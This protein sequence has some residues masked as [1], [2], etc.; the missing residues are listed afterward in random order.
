MDYVLLLL[1]FTGYGAAMATARRGA[2][3]Q[4]LLAWFLPL[5][6]RSPQSQRAISLIIRDSDGGLR[7]SVLTSTHWDDRVA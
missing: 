6:W 2:G 5:S 4:S 1:F 7:P 3:R